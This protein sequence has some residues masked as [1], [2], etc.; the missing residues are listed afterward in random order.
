MK[1]ESMKS[2][3]FTP[4]SK[5]QMVKIRGGEETAG[6]SKVIG[7]YDIMLPCSGQAGGVDYVHQ[8]MDKVW[9][10]SSDIKNGD[11]TVCYKNEG[12][13]WVEHPPS[14]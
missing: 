4:L 14:K 10:Y 8:T 6:A 13:G 12:Y 11:G 2:A 5:D 9:V 3:K 7:T 1:L